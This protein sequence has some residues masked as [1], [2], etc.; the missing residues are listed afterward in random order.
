M[1]RELCAG[2]SHAQEMDAGQQNSRKNQQQIRHQRL[3]TYP[4]Q[5][6]ARLPQPLTPEQVLADHHQKQQSGNKNA[7]GNESPDSASLG[8]D[9]I[10]SGYNSGEQYDTIST[11]YMS[12]EAY[13]LPET[14]MDLHREPALDVIEECIQP[15][16]NADSDENIFRMPTS[17][18]MFIKRLSKKTRQSLFTF[19]LSSADLLLI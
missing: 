14:R 4:G 12:G 11:G 9:E 18:G 15:L 2:Q 10:P 7:A 1:L 6:A 3:Q 16:N 17:I 19:Y 13:E 8:S 5:S